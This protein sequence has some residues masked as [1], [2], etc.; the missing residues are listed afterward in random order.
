METCDRTLL[1]EDTVKMQ[2]GSFDRSRSSR[3]KRM[4]AVEGHFLS[5]TKTLILTSASIW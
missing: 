1:R 2:Q 5:L 3:F 4:L